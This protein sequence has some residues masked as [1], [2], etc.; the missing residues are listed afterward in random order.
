MWGPGRAGADR[1]VAGQ[2]EGETVVDGRPDATTVSD[3]RRDE[4]TVADGGGAPQSVDGPVDVV[5][6]GG[7]AAGLSAAL[8]LARY[9]LETV[10]LDRG[11]SAI[12]RSY[13]VEN[14]L[15]FP[16]GVDPETLL[17]LGRDQVRYEGGTV[18][19]DMVVAVERRDPDPAAA[20]PVGSGFRVRTQDD[21]ALETDA[22]VA[23]TAYDGDYLAGLAGL[24]HAADDHPVPCDDDGRTAVPGL[25]VA[26]W[27]SG[28]PHQVVSCAGHGA[29]VAK[30][31]LEDRRR[32]EGFWPGADQYWDWC[33]ETGTYGDDEW[34][35]H[36][37]EW[38]EDTL[39]DEELPEE[40][41]E[42]I[43][44]RVKRERL[45]F[46]RD[47]EER[48]QRRRDARGLLRE[49]LL[50]TGHTATPEGGVDDG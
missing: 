39:P 15:G 29:T 28:G 47:P 41:V 37:D 12:R 18:V 13:L 31:L 46:H 16:G 19:D 35:G 10:V 14:L 17:A 45:A 9:D 40:R 26:G 3:D 34:A 23:A 38:L 32:A 24:D 43:R 49:H 48:R 2:T 8:F 6:A 11:P 4:R 33:V 25:Y 22:V 27:L 44:E 42:R 5:V 1:P 21:R 20:P 50:E 30:S 36:V 7:G